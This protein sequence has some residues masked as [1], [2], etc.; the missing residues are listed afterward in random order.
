MIIKSIRLQNIRSY[1]NQQIDFPLGSVLLSG[2]IGAGKSTILLAIEFALFGVRRKDL[3]GAALLRHGKKEGEVELRL[4]IDKKDVIIKRKLKRGKED[5]K[6]EAGYIIINGTKKEGTHIELKTHILNLLGYPND[7]I[8]KSKDLIYRY[9]VY[10]PQEAMKQILTEDKDVRLDTLRKVFNIDKYKKIKENS[11][12]FIR[13]LKEKRKNY[14]GRIE[15]LE[16]KKRTKKE[17]EDETERFDR[18]IKEIEPRLEKA[19]EELAERKKSILETEESIK[20]LNELKKEM[21]LSEM[22]F[23]NKLEK[24]KNNIKE[25]KELEK[26][27]ERIR[28]E[29]GEKETKDIEEILKEIK[30]HEQGLRLMST[31][32]LEINKKI[33]EFETR[34]KHSLETKEKIS[35]IE[36]CPTC[37]QK[38]GEEHKKAID[39]KE[40]K[41][42]GE[43]EENIR[44]HKEQETDAKKK[45]EELNKN[46]EGLRKKQYE[47][48]VLTLKKES[49]KEKENKKQEL[50]IQQ[51][52]I[53]QEIGKI[54]M[55]KMELNSQIE[56]L[57][58]IE[59]EYKKLRENLEKAQEYERKLEIEKKG[60]EVNKEEVNKT[61]KALEEE[62][63]RKLEIKKGLDKILQYQNWL[64]KYFTNLMNT[65]E[66]HVM[67]RVYREFNELFQ[68]W[69]STLIED[70]NMNVRLDDEFTPL[71]EQNGY[72]SDVEN[73]SGG[74]KT[75]VALAYRLAL[76]KV[77]NDIIGE[78]KTKD[79]LILDEPTDG[80]SS[81]QLD[82]MRVIL[83]QLSIRQ[84]IIVSHESKI[85]SFVDNVIRIDK[86]EHVSQV[87]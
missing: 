79:I 69:F 43:L 70:E 56:G 25:I 48:K 10:T 8:T 50:E 5:I 64:E 76:N 67:L 78:I 82:K 36:Q 46:V 53:K 33:S 24:R 65:M 1:L 51:E 37:L 84:V 83:E 18:E 71:I 63:N 32:I 28:K 14:E 54:N 47:I 75:A 60:L 11:Q 16:E 34:K 13:E 57:K 81:E 41:L 2:D 55:K 66:K 19:K 4:E 61:V 85:E 3:S 58:N 52:R 74:E 42:I 27:A 29:I 77:I 38:V 15:D 44:L 31:T 59:N 21:Q 20:R 80:F 30:E 7:L 68:Q 6:Q 87:S 40:Q 86:D 26:E 17:K 22:D 72:E 62:I 73:L 23:N 45:V 9:T 39:G 12:I 35:R 49:I